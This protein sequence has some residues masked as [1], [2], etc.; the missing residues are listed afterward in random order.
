VLE[1]QLVPSYIGG[2]EGCE[3]MGMGGQLLLQRSVWEESGVALREAFG[4]IAE[5]RV[6]DGVSMEY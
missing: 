6:E 3:A 4:S 1:Q 5:H 2:A